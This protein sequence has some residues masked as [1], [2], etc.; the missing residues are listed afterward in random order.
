MLYSKHQRSRLLT[1][2]LHEVTAY[3]DQQTRRAVDRKKGVLRLEAEGEDTGSVGGEYVAA[4]G[5]P[6]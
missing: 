4:D 3:E 2:H 5:P 6:A 1:K